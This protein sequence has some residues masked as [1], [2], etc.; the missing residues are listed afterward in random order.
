MSKGEREQRAL[1]RLKQL[2]LAQFEGVLERLRINASHLSSPQAPIAL[3][4]IELLRGLRGRD[5]DTGL[6]AL[7]RELA[8][9]ESSPDNAQG[10]SPGA[11][12]HDH[13]ARHAR[14]AWIHNV[15]L[16]RAVPL[17]DLLV[18]LSI[19]RVDVEYER[20]IRVL[21]RE[22][23]FL[24]D[25]TR[26]RFELREQRRLLIEAFLDPSLRVQVVFGDP[27]SGKTTLLQSIRHAV[28][29]QRHPAYKVPLFISLRRYA[30]LSAPRGASLL[31]HAIT[32]EI[33]A[34]DGSVAQVAAELSRMHGRGERVLVLLDGLD[35][36]ST[37]P[38]LVEHIRHELE[39][40]PYPC[41]VSS[42]RAGF[43][44]GI[45]AQRTCEV[46]DLSEAMIRRLA[47]NW[48]HVVN[49]RSED[50][51]RRFL[52]WVFER[53]STLS[54]ARN[55]CLLTLLCYLDPLRNEGLSGSF[56]RFEL[57]LKAI[58][59]LRRDCHER[60]G[61]EL[62]A[63]DVA[64]MAAFSAHLFFAPGPR[65][66][67]T[68]EQFE[69]FAE[70]SHFDRDA[71]A[72]RWSCSKLINR[73]NHDDVYHFT[74]LSFQEWFVAARL[75][76][77]DDDSLHRIL[78]P[79]SPYALSPYWREVWTFFAGW[80]GLQR[81]ERGDAR[82]GLLLHA[83]IGR[84]DVFN[85]A[86]L[87]AAP[88]IG[89]FGVERA[90]ALTGRA[91]R[92][93]LLAVVRSLPV[94][95]VLSDEL[96]SPH[97]HTRK[98][99]RGLARALISMDPTFC[100][101]WARGVFSTATEPPPPPLDR[102]FALMLLGELR[103]R[104]AQEQLE[105]IVQNDAR[106]CRVAITYLALHSPEAAASF[107]RRRVREDPR[108][109]FFFALL[110]P[111]EPEIA[112]V[113]VE[114]C[115]HVT[116]SDARVVALRTLALRRDPRGLDLLRAA[117]MDL[118][119]WPRFVEVVTAASSIGSDAA[120]AFVRRLL[121]DEREARRVEHLLHVL[122]RW[123]SHLP[124]RTF[125]PYTRG[126]PWRVR[127]RALRCIARHADTDAAAWLSRKLLAPKTTRAV[128]LACLH[129][130]T[131]HKV[132]HSAPAVQA[133]ASRA[134]SDVSGAATH[135]ALRL[136]LHALFSEPRTTTAL[137]EALTEA[138]AGWPSWADRR[139]EALLSHVLTARREA[140]RA[141]LDVLK[142]VLTQT[143]SPRCW[144][145]LASITTR[146]QAPT[147]RSLLLEGLTQAPSPAR[148]GI[149]TALVAVCPEVALETAHPA[150]MASLRLRSLLDGDLFYKDFYIDR[151][152]SRI[153]YGF[154]GQIPIRVVGPR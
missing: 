95:N 131:R 5:S 11:W 127:R 139:R 34:P 121:A 79:D 108:D 12:I 73:W 6:D 129:A 144:S 35:E 38:A 152:G 99:G 76:R 132:T 55:P 104:E 97:S 69:E 44:G 110:C 14:E 112:D 19:S 52:G 31:T 58:T 138:A 122:E 7:E 75:S 25:L 43:P 92:E 61:V 46:M 83:T 62:G 130:I 143:L 91:L 119:E 51:G 2:T 94:Q 64:A 57:Y 111:P 113:V 85:L 15:F 71:L 145:L 133:L 72:L 36:V 82:F 30:L 109:G 140:C 27:G 21:L 151:S 33:G 128:R 37:D 134:T 77:A 42:R 100:L 88:W 87:V 107:I 120:L 20:S 47:T 13:I 149:S 123:A 116:T 102:Y 28:A 9:A 65:Q 78:G 49:G 136:K 56:T 10:R 146:A 67:F 3:R 50:E 86:L 90:E 89:Q 142:P 60:T 74:H 105:S 8:A 40:F 150:L 93:E 53:P 66:L 1:E 117:P 59:M 135:A 125:V 114:A 147:L 41:I 22:T 141:F 16:D 26:E 23:H 24:V 126:H 124:W 80:C 32:H 48:F 148:A 81:D 17:G 106:W 63:R 70:G 118:S 137:R 103:D 4:A 18:E 45:A 154:N 29:T 101:H 96:N 98:I 39:A 68:A 84:P 54:M 115:G 153:P